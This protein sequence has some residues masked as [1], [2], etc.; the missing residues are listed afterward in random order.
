[1][2][3]DFW[4]FKHKLQG[5]NIGIIPNIIS[6]GK[7]LTC[8]GPTYTFNCKQFLDMYL[9]LFTVTLLSITLSPNSTNMHFRTVRTLNVKRLSY[10]PTSFCLLFSNILQRVMNYHMFGNALILARVNHIYSVTFFSCG[11]K[12][13][14]GK[15]NLIGRKHLSCPSIFH[16]FLTSLLHRFMS[17]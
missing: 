16:N 7:V 6:L 9:Y 8:A 2:Y 5:G 15:R 13:A 12:A 3:N 1:M 11:I 17:T 10:L 4:L 14:M